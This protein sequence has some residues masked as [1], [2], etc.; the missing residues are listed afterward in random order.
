VPET[1]FV[2]GGGI[3]G[4]VA[5]TVLPRRGSAAEVAPSRTDVSTS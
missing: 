1:V 5:A 4:L 2:V 3:P